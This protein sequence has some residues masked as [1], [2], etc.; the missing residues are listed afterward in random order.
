MSF[1]VDSV[2]KI[3]R[4]PSGCR[5]LLNEFGTCTATGAGSLGLLNCLFLRRA[6]SLTPIRSPCFCHLGK[7]SGRSLMVPTC[8]GLDTTVVADII[9]GIKIACQLGNDKI[10]APAQL[11]NFRDSEFQNLF[12]LYPIKISQLPFRLIVFLFLLFDHH[13]F[14][15]LFMCMYIGVICMQVPTGAKRGPWFH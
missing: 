4:L 1:G 6:G 2:Y 7:P 3:S 9:G 11:V 13:F 10:K 5:C 12:Y 8:A 14:V 15:C